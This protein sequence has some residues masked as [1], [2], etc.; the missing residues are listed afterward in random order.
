MLFTL[1]EKE[2]DLAKEI[3]VIQ[4]MKKNKNFY[5]GDILNLANFS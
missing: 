4:I 2:N 3:G 1:T 5:Y